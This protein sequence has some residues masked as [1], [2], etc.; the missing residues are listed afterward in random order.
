MADALTLGHR[1]AQLALRAATL[2]DVV[3]LWPA[4]D[5]RH[6][7]ATWGPLETALL[8]LVQARGRS[9]MGLASAYY[10]AHRLAAGVSGAPPPPRATP[11]AEQILSGLRVVGPIE[12]GQ[13]LA[14]SRPIEQVAAA[15]FV[16]LEGAVGMYVLDHGRDVLMNL[17]SADRKAVGFARQTSGSPCAFCAMLASRGPVYRSKSSASFESHRAC[18]CFPVPQ[19]SRDQDWP[20][21][22]EQ[23][24]TVWNSATQGLSGGDALNAFRQVLEG[25]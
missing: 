19:W 4:F 12:A 14:K 22:A 3:R 2:R 6:I 13:A 24:G 17:V 18:A 16:K 11:T 10:R 20:A 8:T 15:T 21:G 25:G 23:F 5:L 1:R 9:S 7:A